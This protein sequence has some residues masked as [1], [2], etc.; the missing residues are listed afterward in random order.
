MPFLSK[1]EILSEAERLGVDLSGLSWPQQQKA[2]IAAQM[3]AGGQAQKE[4]QARYD[5]DGYAYAPES[6]RDTY[7]P[8]AV[9][10]RRVDPIPSWT[11]PVPVPMPEAMPAAEPARVEHMHMSDEP[12]RMIKGKEVRVERGLNEDVKFDNTLDQYNGK[13][14]LLSPEMAQTKIQRLGY[15]EDLG[16]ELTIEETSYKQQFEMNMPIFANDEKDTY[17]S[18]YRVKGKTGRRV[19]GQ[20]GLPKENAGIIFRPDMD[21]F[22]VVTFQGAYGYLWTHQRFPNVK[23]TLM[24]SGYYEK[25]KDRF[26]KTP[27]AMFMLT[28]LECVK[29]E[30]V[31]AVMREIEQEESE[32]RKAGL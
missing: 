28:G 16:D 5:A 18:T 7:A 19:I 3:A 27:Y 24:E 29:I 8:E 9:Y 21:M 12:V 22:P 14:V 13:T 32:R 30:L 20:S 4:V 6:E 31:H 23:A 25:Y 1:A 17:T 11:P 2:V 26:L 10:T 15:D